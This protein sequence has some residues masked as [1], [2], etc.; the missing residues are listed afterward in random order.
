MRIFSLS[1]SLF[2]VA[3]GG[4]ADG[5]SGKETVAENSF[6]I[7]CMVNGET[8]FAPLCTLRQSTSDDGQIL[9][10]SS[11]SGGFR[12][13]RVT[14]DGR[15]VVAADGAVPA[16]VMPLGAKLIEVTIGNDHYRIPA[17]VKQSGR[18]SR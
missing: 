10:L 6:Q 7:L 15:G 17:N 5:T 3:C 18:G 8:Q 16:D 4:Q 9:T 11:P 2:L 14:D 12:R 1:L 13:L